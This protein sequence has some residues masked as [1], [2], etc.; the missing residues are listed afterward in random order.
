MAIRLLA[1]SFRVISG[2]RILELVVWIRGFESESNLL[3]ERL[4]IAHWILYENCHLLDNL[5]RYALRLD[6]RSNIKGSVSIVAHHTYG[7][8]LCKL[9]RDLLLYVLHNAKV[10]VV[11]RDVDTFCVSRQPPL[12]SNC[13]SSTS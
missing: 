9:N 2:T 11:L 4:N 8:I 12:Q 10:F 3:Q 7:A 5:E 6:V 13:C 1:K